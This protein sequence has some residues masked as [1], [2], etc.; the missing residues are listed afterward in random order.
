MKKNFTLIEL[1]VVIA[2]IGILA[3]ML[4]PALSKA[5]QKARTTSCISNMKQ[6]NLYAIQYG[7]AY[8][9]WVLPGNIH[10]DN[11]GTG[12]RAG[13]WP[14]HGLHA[15]LA[16]INGVHSGG[17]YGYGTCNYFHQSRDQLHC[18]ISLFE[19][20]S[21][22]HRI[23]IYNA[24][25]DF[26]SF[27]HVGHNVCLAGLA[28]APSARP[29]RKY[30]SLTS[31]SEAILFWDNASPLNAL[32]DSIKYIAW[33]HNGGADSG[34]IDGIYGYLHYGYGGSANFAACDGHVSNLALRSLKVSGGYSQHII[35]DGYK[36][37][38]TDVIINF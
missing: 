5:R 20:P 36:E 9:G 15:L 10:I 34:L 16:F 29:V 18:D 25:K 6:V 13:D 23:G 37:R 14:F 38:W 33:R 22:S 21:E 8:D 3:A 32:S 27:G 28:R 35:I 2:I 12:E 4:L 19:C 26:M 30:S 7:D 31:P 24:P 17:A 11:G 1:L